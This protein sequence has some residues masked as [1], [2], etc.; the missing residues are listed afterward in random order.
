MGEGIESATYVTTLLR[1]GCRVGQGFYFAEPLEAGVLDSS[2]A[3]GTIPL[4]PT[5]HGTGRRGC[6][7][8]RT[9]S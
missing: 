1:L 3:T 4:L 5:R 6:L 7:T 9:P 8:P 2:F